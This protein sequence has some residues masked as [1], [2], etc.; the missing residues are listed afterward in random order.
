[1]TAA[2]LPDDGPLASA[3]A[4]LLAWLR[5]A[6]GGDVRVA[7]PDVNAT[8]LSVWPLE[9]RSEIEL[10]S[11]RERE[12]LRLRVRHLVTGD[13]VPLG[14]ALAAATTA[15]RPAVDLTP[16]PA[17]TWQALGVAPR[18]ALLVDMPAVILRPWPERPIVTEQ[19][20]L[21]LEPADPKTPAKEA[22]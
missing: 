10:R 16:L 4:A 20:R 18:L 12:P 22:R 2:D 11:H 13:A 6:C 21:T 3:T 1:M 7:A 19:L 5:D 14:K 15:G 8:G 17:Q 9:L